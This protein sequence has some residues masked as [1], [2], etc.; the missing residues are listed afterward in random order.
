M[1]SAASVLA[2][3]KSAGFEKWFSKNEKFDEEF[4]TQFMTLHEEAA[5]GKLSDW[6]TTAEGALAVIILL[7]QF[8]RNSFR[9]TPRTFATDALALET[10]KKAI[11]AGFDMTVDSEL[12]LFFYLPFEHSESLEEQERCVALH[13][14][15]G[16]ANLTKY[17]VVHHEVIARFGRFPH[18]NAILGRTSTADELAFLEG[19]GFAG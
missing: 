19:G 8:P 7:D 13:E 14:A 18:R 11:D 2:F 1:E 3:W 5:A 6:T 12:R 17:A 10:A 15:M 4:R 16:M 9:G